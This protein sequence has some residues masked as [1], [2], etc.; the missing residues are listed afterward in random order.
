[1]VTYSIFFFLLLSSCL[2]DARITGSSSQFMPRSQDDKLQFQ[3]E[4]FRFLQQPKSSSVGHAVQCT[5]LV[6]LCDV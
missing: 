4:A 6:V 5:Y 1:M 2:V 3:L